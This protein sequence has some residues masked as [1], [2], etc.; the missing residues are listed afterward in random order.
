MRLSDRIKDRI[1]NVPG[2]IG[3]YCYDI[4]KDNSCFVGNCDI[5]PSLGI[6]KLIVLIEVFRQAEENIINLTDEYVLEREA[7]FIIPDTEYGDTVGILTFMHKGMRLTVEDLLH[8][9][10]VISDNL[11][12]N[13]LVSLVVIDNVNTTMMKLGLS[14]TRIRR[15]IYDWERAEIEKDNYHS[16]REVGSLMKRMY[17]GQLISHSA[18]NKMIKI[19]RCHQRREILS[20]FTSAKIPVAQQTGFDI[21]CLHVA[22]IVEAEN[23]FILCISTDHMNVKS[24]EEQLRDIAQMCYQSIKQ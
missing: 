18:S 3:V 21:E 17:K 8:M 24:A 12:F 4:G 20:Y 9:M 13:I 1:N 7:P 14:N 22:S 6:A 16:V 5:F 15:G 10:I 11:A 2:E 19:L 23:P